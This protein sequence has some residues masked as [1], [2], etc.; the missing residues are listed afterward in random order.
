MSLD[1]WGEYVVYD[2]DE[3]KVMRSYRV[4][5]EKGELISTGME[6]ETIPVREG[7]DVEEELRKAR[8]RLDEKIEMR[9]REITSKRGRG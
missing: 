7:M 8:K 4:Y 5:D 6:T 2:R 1:E 9:R 3:I